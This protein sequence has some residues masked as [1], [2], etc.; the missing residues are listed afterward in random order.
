[1]LFFGIVIAGDLGFGLGKG[2]KEIII[3]DKE[4]G[5]LL[6]F[7]VST[8]RALSAYTAPEILRVVFRA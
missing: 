6:R 4:F 7:R 8:H 1:M 5:Y 2:S 3:Q